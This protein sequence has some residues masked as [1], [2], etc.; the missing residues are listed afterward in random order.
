MS[1]VPA[2]VAPTES[3]NNSIKSPL[4]KVV[5]ERTA[6]VAAVTLVFSPASIV[7]LVEKMVRSDYESYK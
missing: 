4:E 3:Q 2:T 7:G 5:V 6:A 1:P